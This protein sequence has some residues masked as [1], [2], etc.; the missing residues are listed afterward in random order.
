MID[1]LRDMVRYC[2][3]Q[4]RPPG[5]VVVTFEDACKLVEEL[6]VGPTRVLQGWCIFE[7]VPVYWPVPMAEE[8]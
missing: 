7:G 5:R 8:D 2:N 6:D 1:E 4:G 3:E